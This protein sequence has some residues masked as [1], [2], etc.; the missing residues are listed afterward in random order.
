MS[1]DPRHRA[2]LGVRARAWQSRLL[3]ALPLLLGLA[4]CGWRWLPLAAALL[5]VAT[6]LVLMLIWAV[7]AA[8]RFNRRWITRELDRLCPQLQDS[9][10]LLDADIATLS[11]LTRLQQARARS[12]L[13]GLPLPELRRPWPRR[14]LALTWALGLTALMVARYW[15]P[16]IPPS[17]T[18]SAAVIDSGAAPTAPVQITRVQLDIVA[19]AYTGLPRRTESAL[20]AQLPEG[21]ELTWTLQLQPRPAAVQLRFHD[22]T[23]LPLVASTA[24]WQG[25]RTLTRSTDYRVEINADSALAE[26]HLQRL[27]VIAD[28]PPQVRVLAPERS[29]SL[30]A[31]GQTR[32]SLEF[33]AS[34]DY[35]LGNAQLQIR[36]AQGS[37]ENIQV[38][39]R[40]FTLNGAG[41][42]TLRRYARTLDLT[43][44][45]FAPGDDLIVRLSVSDRRAPQPQTTRSASFILRWPDSA[46]GESEG[47]DG[48]VGKVLP[49]Y[50]R[51]QRQIIIDSEALLAE[52]AAIAAERFEQR[53]DEI[54]VDQRLLRLRYGEFLGEESEGAPGSEHAD[55]H[56]DEAAAA[57]DDTRFGALDSV[58]EAYGHTHDIA[59]AATLLDPATRALLKAALDQMWQSELHLRQAHPA[60]ALPYQY[61]A[62]G[63]IKQVQQASRIY[64]ARVGL[65]LPPVDLSR[66]LSGDRGGLRHRPDRWLTAAVGDPAL[67]NLW[68][69][70]DGADGP[71][72]VAAL[73]QVEAWLRAHETKVADA[74]DLLALLDSARRDPECAPCLSALRARLW[75]LLPT[76]PAAV[77]NRPAADSA[78]RA[79]LDALEGNPRSDAP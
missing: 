27:Q 78:G 70:L 15:P 1:T 53:S 34:D 38:S 71:A 40:E 74:L 54:G 65:E 30:L 18:S 41:S 19:P 45:G 9:T 64:L 26:D 52:R 44:L 55:E 22:G 63:L 31:A 11:P 3:L 4:A 33:E 57:A 35:G 36:H 47:M 23:Q 7:T 20:A 5:L 29:L 51:S 77:V 67:S 76:P 56:A 32:W 10:E 16:T 69:Q 75:P 39:A 21:S 24:G 25:S 49:A 6:A 2:L 72:R 13:D 68:Q 58:L 46:S 12:I 79:Y 48:L 42:A 60:Q 14:Q 73:D 8:R 50:F 17:P 28:Q 61:R 66:R 59:E 37:G 43:A 62:L